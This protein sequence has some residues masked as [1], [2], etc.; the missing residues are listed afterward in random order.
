MFNLKELLEKFK[1][2]QDPRKRKQSICDVL[3][4]RL[5]IENSDLAVRPEQLEVRKNILWLRINPAIR[6]RVFMD[7]STCLEKINLAL[8]EEKIV[9]I[10]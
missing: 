1:S 9:D 2:I 3:N 8:P 7:K 4:Q 6:Q 5:K 10:K